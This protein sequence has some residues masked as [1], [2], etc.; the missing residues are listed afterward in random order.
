MSE[1]E[2]EFSG[3]VE[4][5]Q[6]LSKPLEQDDYEESEIEKLERLGLLRMTWKRDGWRGKTQVDAD[7]KITLLTDGNIP[8]MREKVV[9]ILEELESLPLH[10]LPPRSMPV[11]ELVAY[12]DRDDRGRIISIMQMKNPAEIKE[13]LKS[14][15]LHYR[16]YNIF[17]LDG[18][19]TNFTF[20]QTREYLEK[21]CEGLTYVRPVEM[22]P[23]TFKEMK[24]EV[25][26]RG[27]EGV[28]LNRC[29]F[30]PKFRV[31][32]KL[33]TQRP[34][35]AWKW[36]PLKSGDFVVHYVRIVNGRYKDLG[37]F[38]IERE[39]D[40]RFRTIH[41]GPIGKPEKKSEIMALPMRIV[42]TGRNGQNVFG[43]FINPFVMELKFTDR[44]EKSGK[45]ISP[46]EPTIREDKDV[47]NCVSSITYPE[48][49]Y[50]KFP[51]FDENGQEIA[52]APKTKTAANKRS[53]KKAQKQ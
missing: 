31:D 16:L 35:G 50:I 27:I 49:E 36:K 11:G 21:M 39:S 19:P 2:Y 26:R 5:F 24:A 18:K 42:K 29:D 23:G 51:T 25:I 20:D 8:I 44:F 6:V 13:A 4:G 12:P 38:Q 10:K 46:K 30:I 34:D 52:P 15:L 7:R 22:F 40:K 43:W 3:I 32:G 1:K 47:V 37:L 9:N 48:A 14:G 33:S 41:Y 53:S 28:V 17:F 45:L